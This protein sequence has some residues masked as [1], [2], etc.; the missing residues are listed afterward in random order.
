MTILGEIKIKITGELKF[1]PGVYEIICIPN[2]KKYVG[3]TVKVR[4]RFREHLR[5]LRANVHS[6]PPLQN[7]W[8]KYG[9]ENFEFRVIEYTKGHL[10]L[11]QKC[12]DSKLWALNIN[13]L[14][15]GGNTQ[16]K[17]YGFKHSQETRLK[18]SEI[19]K[20]KIIPLEQRQKMSDAHKGKSKIWLRG[21]PA[22]N[23]GQSPSDEAR[24]KMSEAHR[25][26][27]LSPN[28]VVGIKKYWKEHGDELRKK[29]SDGNKGRPKT[30]EE[31][32]LLSI[33]NTGA[34]N[35]SAK[36][37]EG[38]NPETGETKTYSYAKEAAI[39]GFNPCC[40]GFCC[41]GLQKQH[42]GFFWKFKD[43]E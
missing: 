5:M 32:I 23:R 31:L 7:T 30:E 28:A 19:Q 36:A 12:L 33:A 17:R 27:K 29:I 13:D 24:Q 4:K 25:G 40:I 8:N 22:H 16:F 1:E 11:E 38:L 9:E 6:N 41:R 37:V 10:D 14:A 34:K 35:P 2:G 21:R 26:Q 39:D 15:T 18:L 3:S 43:F 20:G 42:K